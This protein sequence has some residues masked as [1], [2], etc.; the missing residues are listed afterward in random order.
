M[1]ELNLRK[2][3]QRF[4]P[5]C[6]EWWKNYAETRRVSKKK[7]KSLLSSGHKS[8]LFLQE[9]QLNYLRMTKNPSSHLHQVYC[10]YT[11]VGGGMV[12]DVSW[13][14]QLNQIMLMH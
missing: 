5:F 10:T 14:H 9:L 3:I 7:K 13:L 2:Q 1:I 4:L 6:K 12:M 11:Q 8:S